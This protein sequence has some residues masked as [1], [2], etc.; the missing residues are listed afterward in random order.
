MWQNAKLISFAALFVEMIRVRAPLWTTGLGHI[1]LLYL[2]HFLHFP[3]NGTWLWGCAEI[4]IVRG[5]PEESKRFLET[6]PTPPHT[7]KLTRIQT[8]HEALDEAV[9]FKMSPEE[10][11]IYAYSICCHKSKDSKTLSWNCLQSPCY[12][13]FQRVKSLIPWSRFIPRISFIQANLTSSLL[14]RVAK[15]IE[16]NI[17]G[18]KWSV[19][20]NQW[21]FFAVLFVWSVT[22]L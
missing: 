16:N 7:T 10:T 4:Q 21:G 1:V 17:F 8:K 12:T 18:Q 13:F 2:Q 20:A 19:I 5:M 14:T 9:T 3:V 6:I 11:D 15:H 22:C